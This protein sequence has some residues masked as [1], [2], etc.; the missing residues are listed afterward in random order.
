MNVR[1]AA[2]LA[3]V[4]WYLM[5]PPPTLRRYP[6]PIDKTQPMSSWKKIGQL[7][8]DD[9]C[10][11]ALKRLVYE[12]EK[13]G[14]TPATLLRQAVPDDLKSWWAQ[15]IPSDDPRLKP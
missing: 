14:D 2:A 8:S 15:C 6:N 7:D 4:G 11:R 13:P 10:H 3:L 12:G 5:V 9:D 1:H